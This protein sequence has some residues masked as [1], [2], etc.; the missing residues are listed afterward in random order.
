MILTGALFLLEGRYLNE[1]GLTLLAK[2]QDIW[3][4]PIADE[5]V[6][7][8]ARH[9][10]NAGCT[11]DGESGGASCRITPDK[12][13]PLWAPD[14][15][16]IYYWSADEC[17]EHEAWYVPYTGGHSSGGSMSSQPKSW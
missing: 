6:R 3:R 14:Q 1:D 11:C 2:P 4:M 16:P 7:S 10:E 9:G 13:T 12:E 15:T 8:L 17:D 5:I